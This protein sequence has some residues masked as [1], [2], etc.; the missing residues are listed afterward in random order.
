MKNL[1]NLAEQ[2][3]A[4]AQFSLGHMCEMGRGMKK[5]F[6]EAMRWYLR[7]AEQGNADAEFR[8]G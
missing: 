7:A 6:G 8:L 4:G 1:K 5:Y 2:G 3:D